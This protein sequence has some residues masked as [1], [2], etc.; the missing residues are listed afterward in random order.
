MVNSTFQSRALQQAQIL[1]ERERA[2]PPTHPYPRSLAELRR[3]EQ[4][5]GRT[6]LNSLESTPEGLHY[7][8]G[9][10]AIRVGL[11]FGCSFPSFVRLGKR[12]S[13]V[14][15]HYRGGRHPENELGLHYSG[16][17]PISAYWTLAL[18][19]LAPNNFSN[20]DVNRPR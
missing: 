18:Q 12:R 15:A 6:S 16:F 10:V 14:A 19:L 7:I 9:G 20:P 11:V 4:F 8:G 2:Y 1:P 13:M 17:S 5:E 3:L